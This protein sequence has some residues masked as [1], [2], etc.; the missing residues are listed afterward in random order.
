MAPQLGVF[1]FLG[2]LAAAVNFWLH[3]SLRSPTSAIGQ[4]SKERRVVS[5]IVN[6]QTVPKNDITEKLRQMLSSK[7]LTAVETNR[8]ETCLCT[9][10]FQ[11]TVCPDR[12]VW[13]D[14]D[15]DGIGIDLEDWNIE[16]EWDAVARIRVDSLE[17]AVE[18]AKIW[19]LG[20][21]LDNYSN[22][23]KEYEKVF[24]KPIK[25]H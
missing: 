4:K 12:H 23:N 18:I 6:R 14:T 1:Y 24:K 13:I 20:G 25:Q 16:S 10:S 5:N 22:L 19:L 11:S 9:L 2:V 15:L 8:A 21:I 17:D 7:L 3:C